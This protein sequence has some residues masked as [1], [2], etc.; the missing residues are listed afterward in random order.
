LIF[1]G[2][3]CSIFAENFCSIFSL[4]NSYCLCGPIAEIFYLKD[5]RQESF[6]DRIA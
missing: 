2:N 3:F 5:P 1:S 4:M 6:L